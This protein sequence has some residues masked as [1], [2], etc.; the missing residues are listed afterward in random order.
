MQIEY[1]AT[2]M[3]VDHNICRTKL[4]E[5]WAICIKHEYTQMRTT[6]TLP[7]WHEIEWWFL[8]VRDEWDRVTMTLKQFTRDGTMDS[9]K[10]IELI[11]DDYTTWVDF[12]THIW[13]T[14]KAIQESKRELREYKWTQIMLD[15]RPFLE[16]FVEIEWSGEQSVTEL[17][18]KL[19]FD[20][21]QVVFD[22]VTELYARRYKISHDRINQH[23]PTIKFDM[24]NPFL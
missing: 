19:W 12:L 21:S 13:A 2:F 10:E 20:R 14:P 7:T 24:E 4:T 5:L 15:T 8:R 6:F 16:T 3:D 1:E 18:N 11:I 9:Q 23:T 22:S 17:S